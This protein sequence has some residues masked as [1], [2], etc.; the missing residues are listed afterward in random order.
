MT[1]I[2]SQDVA[3]TAITYFLTSFLEASHFDYL[4]PIYLQST[5]SS[6]LA[7][8]TQCVATA[9][10]A[11]DWR[12]SR[13]MNEARKQYSQALTLINAALRSPAEAVKD[14]TLISV[15]LLA[16]FETLAFEGRHSPDD[17]TAHTLGAAA[18]IRL[19]GKAQFDTHLGRR[20]FLQVATNIRVS[21]G[22]QKKHVPE[23][24]RQLEKEAWSNMD[25]SNP[26]IRL[27]ALTDA[28]VNLRADLQF[29]SPRDPVAVIERCEEVNRQAVALLENLPSE[30]QYEVLGPDQAP[31][32]SFRG[33][34]HRY[35]NTRIAL[36]YNAIRMMRLFIHEWVYFHAQ[37]IIEG[38]PESST[39]SVTGSLQDQQEAAK[40][41]AQQMSFDILATVPQFTQLSTTSP[42]L[43][44]R[45][46]IW[47]LSAVGETTLSPPDAREYSVKCL[48]LLGDLS[49][50]QQASKA[51][52]MLE[53]QQI[54]EDWWVKLSIICHA[55]FGLD[56]NHTVP[57][58]HIYHTS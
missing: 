41:I 51:A 56:A 54:L 29:L 21:H 13:V 8:A 40:T 31:S 15:L 3:F 17:W 23:D 25:R 24:F 42:P 45:F 55:S 26:V 57:R 11:S 33:T 37:G 1:L 44:S 7:V 2:P 58:L 35:P 47:P 18:I 36:H 12:D 10:L 20:L 27:S 39:S 53:E 22:Q 38:T 49:R 48:R 14:S 30:Y 46:L 32:W 34:A 5:Q 50:M 16:L 52:E 9:S 4:P 43:T 28:F 6:P 19:R